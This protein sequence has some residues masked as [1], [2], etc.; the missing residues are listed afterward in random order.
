MAAQT[1]SHPGAR[2]RSA[3]NPAEI[4]PAF[5]LELT[6]TPLAHKT[7]VLYHVSAQELAA[8]DRLG[9]ASVAL[10]CFIQQAFEPTRAA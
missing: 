8:E 4:Q 6:A 2:I 3:E 9:F 1:E 7:N 5:I 10:Q